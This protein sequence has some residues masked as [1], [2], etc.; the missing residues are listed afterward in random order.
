M[1]AGMLRLALVIDSDPVCRYVG[2]LLEAL[3]AG[4]AGSARRISLSALVMPARRTDGKRDR[5]LTGA[6]PV[7][8]QLIVAVVVVPRPDVRPPATAAADA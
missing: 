3:A 1:R 8:R 6:A 5:G 2:D 4:D 7:Q